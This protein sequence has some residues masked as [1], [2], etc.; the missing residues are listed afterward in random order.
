MINQNRASNSEGALR[1]LE[2]HAVVFEGMQYSRPGFGNDIDPYTAE[3]AWLLRLANEK[4]TKYEGDIFSTVYFPVHDSFAEVPKAVAVVRVIIHWARFFKHLL[5]ETVKGIIVVLDNSCD[6]P[7]TY[8]INGGDVIPVGHGDLHDPEFDDSM[9]FATFRDV[10]TIP[11]GTTDGMR[12]GDGE[13][14]YQIRIYKSMKFRSLFITSQPVIITVSVAFVFVFTIG[15][16]FVYDRLVERRQKLLAT[17]AQQTGAIVSSLFVS[18]PINSGHVVLTTFQPAAVRDRLMQVGTED[19]E[20]NEGS[21]TPIIADLFPQTTVFFGDIVGFTS[22]SSS[23][24]PEQVF[25]L[26]QTIYQAFD[27]IA[28]KMG[29][30]KVE[31][32]G[33]SVRL[34]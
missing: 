20:K 11:D 16:F 3:I 34:P 31:T 6:E 21:S 10:K 4:K 1:C 30:F 2:E 17:K 18:T 8:E 28:K 29:V 19:V 15:M 22:W 23:R 7:Y 13:C 32:I 26:L 24:G 25:T 12:L 33:D 5:P 27:K 9:T 14:P